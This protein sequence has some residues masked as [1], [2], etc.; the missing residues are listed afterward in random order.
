[1]RLKGDAN[2]D[3]EINAED[4]VAITNYISGNVGDVT[5]ENADVNG[6]GVVDIA[7]IIAVTRI[8]LGN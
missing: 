2:D 8:L 5:E 1:M 3:G 7:D 4:I 6:D